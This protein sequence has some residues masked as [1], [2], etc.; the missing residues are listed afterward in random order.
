VNRVEFER[1]A[2]T[3]A[4]FHREFAPL[5][6]RPEA[7]DHAE[8]YMRGLLIQQTDRRNAENVAEAVECVAPRALQRFLTNSP[9]SS[10]RGIDRL[11]RYV[12]RRLSCPDGLFVIDGSEFPK[13]GTKSVG[14]T[15]QYCGRL[16]KV[17]NCQAGVFL[18]YVSERGHAL[19]A[20]SLYL[21]RVWT[22]DPARCQV[23]GVPEAVSYQSK[24][25][26]ALASLRQ[27]RQAGHLQGRWVTADEDYGKVPTFRDALD[28]EGWLYVLEAPY[29]TPVFGRCDKTEVPAWCGRGPKPSRPRLVAGEP[30]SQTVEEAAQ[31]VAAA[32]WRVLTVAEG[33]Q[34]P[35]RYEFAAQRVWESRDD[36]PGRA[37]WLILRRNL[38]GS[39]L[40]CYLS[41]A[42][43]DTLLSQLAHV[44]AMRWC[45]ETDFQIVKGEAGLDEY[46]VRS[47][48][49]WHH[50]TVLA[51][52]AA[53][54][55]LALRLDWG[56]KDAPDHAATDQ[57]GATCAAPAAELEPR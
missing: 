54:F 27:A 41:N 45:I 51:M 5:F 18:T 28:A 29:R 49:G 7:V 25:D 16:G 47:W 53:A 3:F 38:D 14:V 40:K 42:P 46:E 56:E 23:A 55:L 34:G 48:Q 8:Q 15:R 57:P 39:E 20:A 30:G 24:A 4:D 44:S 31:G 32:D 9:W 37:C 12:G 52:L 22:D 6:G 17:A 10:E 21:P 33:A 36:L 43:A 50:H 1:V 11:Q 26:L 2:E 13:Q 19:V 35:R